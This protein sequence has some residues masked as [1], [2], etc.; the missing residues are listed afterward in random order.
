MTAPKPCLHVSPAPS[1]HTWLP[2]CVFGAL[3][4]PCEGTWSWEAPMGTSSVGGRCWPVVLSHS[5]CWESQSQCNLVSSRV[6]PTS[7]AVRREL[8]PLM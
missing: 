5:S 3:T 7:L 8:H 2:G 1:V 6:L 4:L